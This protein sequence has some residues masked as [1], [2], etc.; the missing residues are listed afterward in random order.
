MINIEKLILFKA[1]T[2]K[3]D[4]I[5]NAEDKIIAV[6]DDNVLSSKAKYTIDSGHML[7]ITLDVDLLGNLVNNIPKHG[8]IKTYA[9]NKND[10]WN[11]VNIDK[12][13][14]TVELTCRHWCTETMLSMFIVDSKPRNLS[15]LAMLARLVKN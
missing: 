4:L 12:N 14:D 3:A 6:L 15:G 9:Q 10:Y 11:I 13:L 1:E 8:V 2:S 5:N 7:Y